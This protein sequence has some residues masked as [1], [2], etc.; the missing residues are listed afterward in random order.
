MSIVAHV[1]AKNP[2]HSG[3]NKIAIKQCAAWP[4]NIKSL[5]KASL[6]KKSMKTSFR[7]RAL[8]WIR[9]GQFRTHVNLV[10]IMM[11]NAKL[12][13]VSR[14]MSNSPRIS[15]STKNN[16]M[17]A[18]FASDMHSMTGRNAGITGNI[19]KKS[20]LMHTRSW[21]ASFQGKNR[22]ARRIAPYKLAHDV[23][24]IASAKNIFLL[25]CLCALKKK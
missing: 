19:S 9:N 14:F 3:N 18:T 17:A 7:R 12:C 5:A 16:T 8:G 11:V 2:I 21:R 15:V 13:C 22:W 1:R 10:N 25:G 23:A 20:S 6:A 4:E 24:S